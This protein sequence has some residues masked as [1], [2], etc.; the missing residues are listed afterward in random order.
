MSEKE[1]LTGFGLALLIFNSLVLFNAPRLNEV[2][3]QNF[4]VGVLIADNI[5]LVSLLVVILEA[6]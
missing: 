2:R 3:Y 6:I 5:Y 1:I 4:C